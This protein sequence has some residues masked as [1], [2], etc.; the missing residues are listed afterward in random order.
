MLSHSSGWRCSGNKD[1]SGVGRVATGP[2]RHLVIVSSEVG[3]FRR[4]ILIRMQACSQCTGSA[5]W[6]QPSVLL[7]EDPCTVSCVTATL[8]GKDGRRKPGP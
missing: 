8:A 7:G 6:E 4:R 1:H 5:F 2:P 3:A